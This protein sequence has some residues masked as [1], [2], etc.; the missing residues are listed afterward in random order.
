[1]GSATLNESMLAQ[2]PI[3]KLKAESIEKNLERYCINQKGSTRWIEGWRQVHYDL[4]LLV[5]ILFC[6]FGDRISLGKRGRANAYVWPYKWDALLLLSFCPGN[7]FFAKS[8]FPLSFVRE[9][10]KL[11]KKNRFFSTYQ[12]RKRRKIVGK[13]LITFS[14]LLSLPSK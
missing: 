5:S 10:M 9:A 12:F 1:M 6:V 4:S 13:V 14:C 8:T 2:Y 11:L 3:S 7:K